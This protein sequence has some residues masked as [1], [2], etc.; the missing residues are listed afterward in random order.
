MET[1][2]INIYEFKELSPEAKHRAVYNDQANGDWFRADEYMASMRA[3]AVHF[4][5]R[6]KDWSIDWSNSSGP[7]SMEFNM[8]EDMTRG[9]ILKR[10][11]ALGGFNRRTLMGHGE[12]K[13][14]GVC[15]DESAID[16][17]RLA[18]YRDKQTDLN[19]LMQAAFKTWIKASWAD[20]EYDWD[21]EKGYAET[22]EANDWRYYENGRM[23]PRKILEAR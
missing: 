15:T 7:S 21:I 1:R 16:G 12:C 6:V 19:A 22:A 18:F 5:G 8:P 4:D 11:R 10:L 3:L 23:V 13:L 9:E 17:F 20:W 14:T 2:T